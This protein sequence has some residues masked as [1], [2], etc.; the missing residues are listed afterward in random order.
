MVY[1]FQRHL[2][3]NLEMT[4]EEIEEM[5]LAV[6]RQ[7]MDAEARVSWGRNNIA[8]FLR[9]ARKSL[10]PGEESGG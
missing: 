8:G 10:T 5:K 3:Q 2:Y 4:G 1:D 6:A 9:W 7:K